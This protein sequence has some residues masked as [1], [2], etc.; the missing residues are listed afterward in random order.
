MYSVRAFCRM[1]Y[2]STTETTTETETGPLFA[3]HLRAKNDPNGNPRRVFVGYNEWGHIVEI[4]D[5]GYAGRP[6][7]LRDMN[8]RGVWETSSEITVTEYRRQMQ[9]AKAFHAARKAEG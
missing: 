4:T 7:W 3:L 1:I 8:A 9:I 2:M 6:K 5:E